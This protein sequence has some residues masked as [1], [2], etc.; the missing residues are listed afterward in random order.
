MGE[1]EAV[2]LIITEYFKEFM[3]TCEIQFL[4]LRSNDAEHAEQILK[5]CKFN[6]Y[7]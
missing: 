5:P 4:P 2:K 1:I 7:I 3:V 6:Y